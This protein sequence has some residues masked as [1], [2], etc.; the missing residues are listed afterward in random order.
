MRNPPWRAAFFRV[1]SDVQD[2]QLRGVR[3]VL[4]DLTRSG[5]RPTIDEAASTI[6]VLIKRKQYAEAVALYRTVSGARPLNSMW[7]L[8]F[9]IPTDNHDSQQDPFAWSF[10]AKRG[11]ITSVEQSGEKR[12]L[13]LGTNGRNH[14]QPAR[15]YSALEA[16]TYQLA[17]AMRGSID[18]PT[19]LGISIYC[20]GVHQVLATSS[21]APLQSSSDFERRQINFTVP[22][23]CQLVV[24]AFETRLAERAT[25]AE[26]TDLSIQSI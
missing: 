12:V 6:R 21:I 17:Y 2:E 16:G 26:F 23:S 5:R 7:D 13:V 9:D 22:Q 3:R 18:S 4:Q 14:N 20:V 11:S 8:R 24:L 1:S 10:A 15:K 19:T 25:Q